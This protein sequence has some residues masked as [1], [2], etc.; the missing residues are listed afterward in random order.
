MK[1]DKLWHWLFLVGIF[2]KGLDGVLE[3]L[4]GLAFLFLK[5]D[6]TTKYINILFQRQLL[7]NPPQMVIDGLMR[8]SENTQLFVAVYLLGHGI[9]KM[10]IVA[11][12]YLKKL[13]VY[14]LAQI[15]LTLFVIYQSYRFF[16]T[17]SLLLLFLT[18]LDIF[19]IFLIRTES[20]RLSCLK[21]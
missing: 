14:P 9:I 12:L 1:K 3:F 15:I 5:H 2:F 16:H 11:G 6:L 13:W 19:I 4:A 7:Q 20:K 18:G 21:L 10:G 17:F 8:F